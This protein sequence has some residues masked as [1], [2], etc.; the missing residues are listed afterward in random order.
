MD[1][2]LTVVVKYDVST[3]VEVAVELMTLT[4]SLQYHRLPYAM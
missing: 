1:E 4:M 3:A 2:R